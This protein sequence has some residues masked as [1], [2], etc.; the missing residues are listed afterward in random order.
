[1]HSKVKN[2]HT[3]S[4]EE[5]LT[6]LKTSPEGLSDEEVVRRQTLY[7]YNLIPPPKPKPAILRFLGQFQHILIYIL[8]ATVLITL[9]LGECLNAAVIF[10]VILI[11]AII[12]FLQEGKAEEALE[13]VSK[14]L[15]LECV[16]VRNKKHQVI[17]AEQLVPGDIVLLQSGDKVPADLRLIQADHLQINEMILTGESLP[18]EKNQ[19]QLAMQPS[20]GEQTNMAFSGTLVSCGRGVGIVTGTGSNTEIG[21]IT[22]LLGQVEKSAT[23]LLRKINHFS[24]SLGLLILATVIL[25]FLTGLFLR[26][27]PVDQLLMIS[28]GIAV[29]A[30]PEGLPVILTV[31]LAIGVRRMAL[32]NA[33]IR[34][35]PAVETLGSVTVICTDKTGTLTRNEMTVTRVGMIDQRLKV[36]GVGYEVYGGF[37]EHELQVDPKQN[38]AFLLLC[39]AGVLCNES[40]FLEKHGQLELQGDPTEGALLILGMKAGYNPVSLRKS[41]PLT[42]ILPFESEHCFMATLHHDHCGNGMIYVK[43]APEVILKYCNRSIGKAGESPITDFSF[44]DHQVKEMAE[45][46]LRVLALAFKSV[47]SEHQTLSFKD[48]TYGFVLLGVVGMIDPARDEAI[49]AIAECQ[50]AG[51]HVKMITGDHALTASAIAE[52]MGLGKGKSVLTGS[53]LED[54]TD[55]QFIEF[56]T[57]A[58]VFARTT[59]VQKLR[60]VEALQSRGQIVAMTGDGVNDAPALKRAEIGVAM[61]L[62]GSEAAKEASEMVLAD[63]NFASIVAAIKEG[64]TVFD[65]IKKVIFFILP[66][67]AGEAGSLVVATL[68]GYTLPITPLQILWVNM[69]SSVALTMPLAFEASDDTVMLKKPTTTQNTLNIFLLGQVFLVGVL[70]LAGIFFAFEWALRQGYSLEIARTMSVN[71][72]VTLEIAYLLSIRSVNRLTL[73]LDGIKKITHAL[74]LAILAVLVFQTLLTYLP[75][76]QWLFNTA[77]LNITQMGVVFLIGTTGFFLLEI[78]KWFRV[79]FWKKIH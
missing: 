41:Y 48:I 57:Q 7:G 29:S 40:E 75:F 24:Y 33:I 61:G 23:P 53:F 62:K 64:R 38:M 46:G 76:M 71:S 63:D 14:L 67:N 60:L 31:V 10:L 2:W 12:G 45:S 65:N 27:Y 59:A 79:R 43:G 1:M 35:L 72:L 44:W 68:M 37:Y 20:I 5:V 49:K 56:A 16:V 28:V 6:V 58:D 25:I 4:V 19:T 18:V 21:R 3:L 22:E 17:P 32:R 11:N 51:I 36:S 66:I 39:R 78:I 55:E 54:L 73:G 42:G 47:P 52:Q 70:F 8:L 15:S 74:I 50:S 30:I 9:L 69:V 13:A 34:R 77:S 26:A